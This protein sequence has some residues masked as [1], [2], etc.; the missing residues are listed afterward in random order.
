[1]HHGTGL[2][3]KNHIAIGHGTLLEGKDNMPQE[4]QQRDWSSPPLSSCFF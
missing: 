4:L 2:N 3:L 1:M